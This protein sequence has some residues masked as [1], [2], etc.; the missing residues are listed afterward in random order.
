[1][2]GDLNLTNESKLYEFISTAKFENYKKEN[3]HSMSGQFQFSRNPK[4]LGESLLPES[5]GITDQSQFKSEIERRLGENSSL[6]ESTFGADTLE[7]RFH[8][9]SVY[10]H[11][12]ENGLSEITTCMKNFRS[13]V[14]FIFY[15]SENNG[16][17]NQITNDCKEEFK[18]SIRPL[19]RLKLFDCNAVSN[20]CIPDKYYPSDHFMLAAEFILK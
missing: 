7:H 5:L 6:S 2:C 18:G 17:V 19:S 20:Y 15:H 1:M 11:Q 16:Y 12:N 4:V 13:S 9:Y 3:I 8:F 14:D 10:T